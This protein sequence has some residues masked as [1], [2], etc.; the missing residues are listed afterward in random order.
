[1]LISTTAL[2]QQ[3]PFPTCAK[4]ASLWC[5]LRGAR[6]RIHLLRDLAHARKRV[7]QDL[8]PNGVPNGHNNMGVCVS[9]AR[10][11][12]V[13]IACACAGSQVWSAGK[14][15]SAQVQLGRFAGGSNSDRADAA[16]CVTDPRLP[17]PLAL[18]M[19]HRLHGTLLQ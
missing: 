16:H 3:L 17:L 19:P 8:T 10:P 14:C 1:M 6:V 2:L 12:G 11:V 7:H 18:A 5:D 9:A 13:G 4:H 15:G